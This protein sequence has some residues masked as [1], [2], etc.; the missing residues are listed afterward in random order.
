MQ[1]FMFGRRQKNPKWRTDM[2]FK[3]IIAVVF[4]L[5]SYM[6]LSAGGTDYIPV[7]GARP[8][9]LNGLYIAGNSGLTAS[10]FN[11]ASLSLLN[12]KGIELTAIDRLEQQ[13]FDS[14]TNGLYNSFRD[15]NSSFGGG[16]YW[17]L[18]ENI[19]AALTYGQIIDYEV[20]WPYAMV[21]RADS[22]S[23]LL[24]F[25]MNNITK[26]DAISPSIAVNL[27]SITLGLSANI[28]KISNSSAFPLGNPLWYSKGRGTAAYQFNYEQNAWSFGGTIGALADLSASLKLGA[29]IKS[30]F[31]AS[32]DGNAKS[33]LFSSVDSSKIT[34]VNIKSN[35]E[36]PWSM[37]LGFVY[38]I[39]DDLSLNVDAVYS[40]WGS[41][42]KSLNINF[43]NQQ[44]Q[45]RLSGVD[46]LTGI[47]PGSIVLSYNNT[48]DAG[49]GFEYTSI[50]GMKYRIGYRYSQS[51]NSDET[52]N[53]LLPGIDKHWVTAGFGYTDENL[54]F[55]AAIAYSFG[56]NKE[57]NRTGNYSTLSGKYSSDNYVPTITLQYR[58]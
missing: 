33:T 29:F 50:S 23:A 28:Y 22:L 57:I 36:L 5:G 45:N 8:L 53:F 55:D 26:V 12:G 11:P 31:K 25:D 56:F 44:W 32:M 24:A 18:N 39:A 51:P 2:K 9:A 54:T 13:V 4:I 7:F 19:T 48:L 52:Y 3:I 20:N 27:G 14:R 47:T 6:Q 1:L 42:Q 10:F 21:R 17:Q 41:T 16:L 35:Y 49:F 30:G 40:L 34:Q 37:G 43:D 38:R 46:S 15:N 58:F